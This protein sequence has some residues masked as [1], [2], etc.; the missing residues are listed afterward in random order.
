MYP[1]TEELLS[2]RDGEPVDANVRAEVDADP[3]LR[4]EV[5]QLRAT[6]ERLREL[7]DFAPPPGVRDKV[8][9]QLDSAASGRGHRD[10]AKF[11]ATGTAR[12]GTSNVGAGYA[13]RS[14]SRFSPRSRSY[15]PLRGAIAAAVAV[16]AVLAVRY[17]DEAMAPVP[18]T[19]VAGGSVPANG[20]LGDS[21]AP[22][23]YTSLSSESARLERLLNEIRYQPR[24]MNAATATT[25]AGL[26]DQIALVDQQLMYSRVNGLQ[27]TQAEALWQERV[28]LM[29]A[30]L[31]VRYA[32]AQRIGF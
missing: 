3:H 16:V 4:A 14:R 18:S 23:T 20:D 9:A 13:V 8:F 30:L 26:Q 1:G 22:A 32:Q 29:N 17:G 25:I 19:T 21:V 31:Q 2:I 27:A 11:H 12:V 10:Q 5:A 7:P 28:D 24:L 15:W 6:R